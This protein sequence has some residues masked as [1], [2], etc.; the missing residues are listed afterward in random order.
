MRKISNYCIIKLSG[1]IN[2]SLIE[3]LYIHCLAANV[4]SMLL[5]E[6]GYVCNSGQR[7]AFFFL[8]S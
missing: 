8:Q 4:S 7:Q 2:L 6:L 3:E 1:L 5:V